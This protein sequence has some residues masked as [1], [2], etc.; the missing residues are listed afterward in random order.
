MKQAPSSAEGIMRLSKTLQRMGWVAVL[1]LFAA[2]VPAH[3]QTAGITGKATL[4]DGSL[5]VGCPVILDRLE[6]KGTYKCKTN[7]KGNYTYIGLPLGNYKITLESPD[8]QVLFYF[9]NKRLGLGDPVEVNFDLAKEIAAAKKEQEANPEYQKKEQQLEKENKQIAGLKSLYEEGNALFDQKKFPEAADKFEQALPLAQGK[10]R[11]AV[12]QR[13]AD[14]Y[15]KAKD[16]DKAIATYQQAIEADP[17]AA[18]LHNNLG[19]V[20]ADSGDTEKAKAE[21]EKAAQLDPPGA[22]QYYFNLGA[23]LY[24][25]GK[26]DDSVAAFKKATETDPK[27]ANAYFWLGQALLG[28]ATTGEGGKVVAAPGT[29]EAFQTY[30]QLDPNGPNVATAQAL[31]QTIEGSVDTS[32]TKKKKKP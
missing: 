31:L 25:T 5:C 32:Y 17:T 23:V 27:F 14:T 15:A 18:A 20:Y 9:N 13:L 28:K 24:N 6:I 7:K 22:A 12:L 2:A 21:F 29:K 4:Q 19:N 1:A 26:M 8:G 3:A 10:N 30:L 16:R 11:E